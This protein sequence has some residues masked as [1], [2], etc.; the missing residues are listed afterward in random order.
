MSYDG[1]APVCIELPVTFR[2]RVYAGNQS[3]KLLATSKVYPASPHSLKC[4]II[5]QRLDNVKKPTQLKQMFRTKSQERMKMLKGDWS[6]SLQIIRFNLVH[7]I[8][9]ID[10]QL[11]VIAEFPL[12]K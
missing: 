11:F 8:G 5:N 4:L 10:Y 2:L 9:I 3:I 12:A 7:N 1:L 6:T